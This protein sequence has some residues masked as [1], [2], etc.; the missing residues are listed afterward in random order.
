MRTKASHCENQNRNK[1]QGLAKMLKS[2]FIRIF[3]QIRFQWMCDDVYDT[4]SKGGFML[5][6]LK[7]R[8]N[9]ID[10][11]KWLHLHSFGGEFY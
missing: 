2:G 9:L 5:I 4:M 3:V 7:I 8:R 11:G 6:N 10:C 1:N